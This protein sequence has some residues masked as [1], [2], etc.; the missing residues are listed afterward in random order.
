MTWVGTKHTEPLYESPKDWKREP[1][2]NRRPRGYEPRILPLNYLAIILFQP[3]SSGADLQD[4]AQRWPLD[5][6]GE[7]FDGY[8]A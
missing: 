3:S 2:S 6:Q 5:N 1:E 4:E 8:R 7:G